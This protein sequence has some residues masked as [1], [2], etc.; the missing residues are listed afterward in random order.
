MTT[1]DFPDAD[2]PPVSYRI[3][4]PRI[5]KRWIQAN[6]RTTWHVKARKTRQWR[7]VTAWRC[8]KLG[9]S[10]YGG[11][12]VLCELRFSTNRRRD[13]ANWAPTAKAVMDGLVDAGVFPDD[14]HRYV[15]G[16][17]MRLGPID[18]EEQLIVHIFPRQ[19]T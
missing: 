19:E 11:A 10:F 9:Y 16:P 17:D 15:T 2:N 1:P 12:H 8:R 13:P 3:V 4:V 7:D 6:E 5:G 14:N 18:D